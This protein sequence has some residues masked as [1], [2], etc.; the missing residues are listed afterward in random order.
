MK[1]FKVQA[2]VYRIK[3][4]EDLKMSENLHLKI[5]VVI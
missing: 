2:W 3:L 5:S 1:N 4:F